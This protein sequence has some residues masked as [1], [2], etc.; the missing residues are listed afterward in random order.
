MTDETQALCERIAALAAVAREAGLAS[1]QVGDIAFVL[2]SL[3]LAPDAISGAS[4]FGGPEMDPN[5]LFGSTPEGFD[6]RG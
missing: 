6:Y 4:D 1:L 5:V 3:P 2:G